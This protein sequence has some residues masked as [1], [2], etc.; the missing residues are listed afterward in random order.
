M[1]Q[2]FVISFPRR[3]VEVRHDERPVAARREIEHRTAALASMD[4]FASLTDAERAALARQ[5]TTSPYVAGER[6]FEASQPAD[7]L[8]LLA[9]GHVEITR[10]RDKGGLAVKLA[11]LEA[12]A[13]FGEMG[14]LLGQPRIATVAAVDDALCY[15]LDKRGF[16]SILR[17]RPALAEALARILAERQAEND[18]KLQALDAEARAE[19]AVGRTRELVRKIQQ[20]FG[21]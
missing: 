16:D 1:R 10:E 19:H 17:G 14:L 4:L 20:F 21:L 9:Q 2:G 18:A 8:Y 5:L 12:P 15:R 13:Y 6:I 3:I 11:T 7:S